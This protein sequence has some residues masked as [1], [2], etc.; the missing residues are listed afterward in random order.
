MEKLKELSG[1]IKQ[2]NVIEVKISGLIGHPGTIANIGEYIAE[3]VFSVELEKSKTQRGYDGKFT[4]GALRGRTVNIKIARE[5]EGYID[6]RDDA[7]PEY[8][9]IITGPK[10]TKRANPARPIHITN[11]YLFEVDSTRRILRKRGVKPPK[12]KRVQAS[13]IDELWTKAE[14]YPNQVCKEL[15]VSPA[16]RAQL[17]L[18]N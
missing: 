11:V 6:W 7:L 12:G 15:R 13:V 9:L 17:S 8:F 5:R 3:Q 4:K 2:W 1:L 18:F 14:I 10:R 16:Q